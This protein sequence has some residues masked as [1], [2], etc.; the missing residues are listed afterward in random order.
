MNMSYVDEDMLCE[1]KDIILQMLWTWALVY[2][3]FNFQLHC[4]ILQ[5]FCRNFCTQNQHMTCWAQVTLLLLP[6][7]TYHCLVRVPANVDRRSILL[8]LVG[9]LLLLGRH[10]QRGEGRSLRH[11]RAGDAKSLGAVGRG[12]R[13]DGK[14]CC[15]D[16]HFCFS[17]I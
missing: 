13:K 1:R 7:E 11:E 5:F 10:G 8:L 9:G 14:D 17:G 12:R 2:K 4:A 16:L 15:S 3:N 6:Q